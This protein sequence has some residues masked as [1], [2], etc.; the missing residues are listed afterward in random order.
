MT[1]PVKN[2]LIN[3]VNNIKNLVLLERDPIENELVNLDII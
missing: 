3:E 1:D 2:E